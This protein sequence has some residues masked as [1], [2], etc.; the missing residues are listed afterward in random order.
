MNGAET[1]AKVIAVRFQKAGKL[2]YF[3]PADIWVNAG[4]YVIVETVR[5][6]ELGEVVTGAREVPEEAIVA[7]LKSVL[8]MATEE[9]LRRPEANEA[10]EKI[11]FQLG[12]YPFRR[13]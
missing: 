8:R 13:P 9:D 12:T 7:P 10:N 3:D 6:I 1:M 4:D 2:Y 11:A 5:G